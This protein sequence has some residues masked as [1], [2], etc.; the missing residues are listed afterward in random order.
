L[1]DRLETD[2][3]GGHQT[4]IK[5]MLVTTGVDNERTIRQKG[6]EPDLVVSSLDALVGL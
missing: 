6:I 2:I 5:T 4:G 3:R 1:G